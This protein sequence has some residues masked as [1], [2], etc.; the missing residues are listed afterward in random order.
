MRDFPDYQQEYDAMMEFNA[1]N[2]PEPDEDSEELAREVARL[3][4]SEDFPTFEELRA[5]GFT[6]AKFSELLHVRA[7]SI[8]DKRRYDF[9]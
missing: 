4:N 8:V 6:L 5:Y 3:E 9:N 1:T 7:Q 2:F